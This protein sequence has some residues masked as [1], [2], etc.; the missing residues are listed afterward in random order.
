MQIHVGLRSSPAR[1]RPGGR[2]RAAET[3]PL[4]LAITIMRLTP[5]RHMAVLVDISEQVVQQRR[6]GEVEAWFSALAEGA[7]G[8]GFFGLDAEGR[9]N[10]WNNSAQRLFG[11]DAANAIGL[12]GDLLLTAP[13]E[14]PALS[15]RLSLVR[16]EGWQVLEGWMA[17]PGGTRF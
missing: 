3:T 10:D 4:V 13:G 7:A 2:V 14:A 1:A 11:L 5:N 16:G 6:L 12:D 15:P 9:V 17:G 8:Y